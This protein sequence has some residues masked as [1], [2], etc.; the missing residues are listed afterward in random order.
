MAAHV[1]IFLDEFVEFVELSVALVIDRG[2]LYLKLQTVH[3]EQGGAVDGGDVVERALFGGEVV[4]IAEHIVARIHSA[5]VYTG[6]GVVEIALEHVAELGDNGGVDLSLF[7]LLTVAR[8]GR[9]QR[10]G[11]EKREENNSLSHSYGYKKLLVFIGS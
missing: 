5:V 10:E 9:K 7:L 3:D 2:L 1:D 4:R 6:D 11:H 8:A